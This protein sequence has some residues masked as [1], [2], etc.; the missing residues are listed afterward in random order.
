MDWL[1]HS[2]ERSYSPPVTTAVFPVRLL[3]SKS[4][5]QFTG[6]AGDEEAIVEGMFRD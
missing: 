6:V 3:A 1:N 5:V 4:I 2:D